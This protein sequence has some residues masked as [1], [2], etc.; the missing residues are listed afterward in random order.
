MRSACRPRANDAQAD[1]LLAHV[2]VGDRPCVRLGE[3]DAL[4]LAGH[5]RVIEYPRMMFKYGE[6][7]VEPAAAF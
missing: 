1:I 6:T 5:V 4:V 3:N 2:H 7:P